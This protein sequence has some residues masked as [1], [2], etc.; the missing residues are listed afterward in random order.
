MNS[1][2]QGNIEDPSPKSFNLS[3]KDMKQDLLR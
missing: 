2:I 3:P 1:Q